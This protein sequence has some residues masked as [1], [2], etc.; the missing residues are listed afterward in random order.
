[1]PDPE[2]LLRNLARC[3]MEAMA[4][5]RDLEQMARW[6]SDAAYKHLLTR[7]VMA[8]RAREVLGRTAR[9]PNLA[10]GKVIVSEPRAGIVEAVVIVHEP[11]RTR[12]VAIRLEAVGARWRASAI[13]IL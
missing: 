2:P 1:M 5:A 3:G 8:A 7:V 13:N 10:T 9:R 6:V 12:A 11:G 4:G